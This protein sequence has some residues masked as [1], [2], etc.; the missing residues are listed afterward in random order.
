MISLHVVC[1][2]GVPAHR[3]VHFVDFLAFGG[4]RGFS[5]ALFDN[6]VS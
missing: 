5:T 6:V 4:G 1:S 2:E 3:M